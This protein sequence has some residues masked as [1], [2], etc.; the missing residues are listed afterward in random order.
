MP[1]RTSPSPRSMLD[2]RD[3]EVRATRR[4]AITRA[5][6]VSAG[7]ASRSPAAAGSARSPRRAAASRTARRAAARSRACSASFSRAHVFELDVAARD[8][9]DR[10]ARR[11]H[12]RLRRRDR[13]AGCRG[14]ARTASP[15]S[16]ALTRRAM[17]A[18]SSSVT[19]RRTRDSA[20]ALRRSPLFAAD[21]PRI[22][23]HARRYC[24]ATS[25][26]GRAGRAPCRCRARPRDR[27]VRRPSPAGR[28]PRAAARRGC[29]SSAPPPVSTMPLSTMSAASSGGV[30][31]SAERTASTICVDR[32]GQRLADLVAVHR[33]RSWARRR[34]GRGP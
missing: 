9:A 31:S 27:V 22:A 32:L 26:A 1:R 29:C 4:C 2:A 18:A 11:R 8:A 5:A 13:C 34:P 14:R 23:L 28:S 6:I 10:R 33:P 17:I 19:P 12:R 25:R 15:D 21:M 24:S 16:R 30:R 3:A 20:L 7:V